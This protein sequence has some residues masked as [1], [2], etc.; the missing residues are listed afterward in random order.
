M[1][2]V[3]VATKV[4][5]GVILAATLAVSIAVAAARLTLPASD[6]EVP[7]ERLEK[8]KLEHMGYGDVAALLGC[9]GIRTGRAD[10][11]KVQIEDY[12]WR[13][14][15]WPYGRF[16]GHFINGTLHGTAHRVV[17]INLQP[18]GG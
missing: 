16:D 3:L 2:Y 4:L 12:A 13:L 14:A 9:D 17:K 18:S 6:C 7:F 11:G 5:I 1:R 8:L 15:A 10:Y